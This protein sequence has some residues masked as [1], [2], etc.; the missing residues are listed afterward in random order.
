[1]AG[2]AAIR[3]AITAALDV[4]PIRPVQELDSSINVSGSAV[5]AAVEY[6]G[7]DYLTM[8]GTQGDSLAFTVTCLAGRVSERA[9]R[10]KLD[11]LV[12]PDPAASSVR[13]LLNGNLGGLVAWCTVPSA[14]EYRVYPVGTGE[15]L[16]VEF[17]VTVGT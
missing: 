14:T 15:Y 16:G 17:T 8:F 12:D 13:N 6:A 11:A 9:A 5:V 4:S 10:E 3:D 7:A 2:L 1:M